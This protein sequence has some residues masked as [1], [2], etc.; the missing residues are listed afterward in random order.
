MRWNTQH[1]KKDWINSEKGSPRRK[2]LPAAG[3]QASHWNY[4]LCLQLPFLPVLCI[5]KRFSEWWVIS[6]FRMSPIILWSWIRGSQEFKYMFTVLANQVIMLFVRIWFSNRARFFPNWWHGNDQFT[7][8]EQFNCIVNRSTADLIAFVFHQS[9]QGIHIKVFIGLIHFIQGWNN[10]QQFFLW[11]VFFQDIVW[12][13]FL[14]P[15][16]YPYWTFSSAFLFT[17]KSFNISNHFVPPSIL[18]T[19]RIPWISFN[20][21]EFIQMMCIMHKEHNCSFKDT[22]IGFDSLCFAYSPSIHSKSLLKFYW[23]LPLRQFLSS[24]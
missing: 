8:E 11:R 23:Q 21:D 18:L 13:F 4:F 10:A 20:F 9:I 22:I 24:G 5:S 1:I 3:F 12:K 19:V 15:V 6:N 17:T 16:Y 2:V 14:L 7:I